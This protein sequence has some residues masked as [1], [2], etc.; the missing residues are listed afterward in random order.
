MCS[1]AYKWIQI[2]FIYSEIYIY[3]IQYFERKVR[4]QISCHL[5]ID[6]SFTGVTCR[7]VAYLYPSWVKR[8]IWVLMGWYQHDVLK[9]VET[10]KF[11]EFIE[12]TFFQ[13][14]VVTHSQL[15]ETFWLSPSFEEPHAG[16]EYFTLDKHIAQVRCWKCN[17]IVHLV[18]VFFKV[19][20]SSSYDK[21]A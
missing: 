5:N 4:Q 10:L 1:P 21:T 15:V 14:R 20:K 11:A 19:R 9:P 12:S 16:I 3:T 2:L 18:R 17:E 7:I 13:I 6:I 8:C